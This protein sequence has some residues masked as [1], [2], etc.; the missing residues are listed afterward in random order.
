MISSEWDILDLYF[1][2]HK[3]PFT[4][5]HLD[6][7]RDFIKSKIPYIIKSYNPITMIKY[8]DFDNIIMKV[9]FF[10]SF[11]RA[12]FHFGAMLNFGLIVVQS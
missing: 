3:Y 7:Y 9:D 2:D 5:H 8:D 11:Q 4:G 6:S 10:A 1:K 12:C